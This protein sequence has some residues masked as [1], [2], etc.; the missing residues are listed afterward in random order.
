MLCCRIIS[1]SRHSFGRRST[2]LNPTA[3]THEFLMS[4]TVPT[5]PS[6]CQPLYPDLAE[7]HQPSP[8]PSMPCVQ[9]TN[10]ESSAFASSPNHDTLSESQHIATPPAPN[11]YLNQSRVSQEYHTL[12]EFNSGVHSFFT[13]GKDMSRFSQYAANYMNESVLR[14]RLLVPEHRYSSN[15]NRLT[16]LPPPSLTQLLSQLQS[17]PVPLTS[18]VCGMM[19]VTHSQLLLLQNTTTASV[20]FDESYKDA[21]QKLTRT[22]LVLEFILAQHHEPTPRNPCE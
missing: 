21:L 6:V 1:R 7:H 5:M 9:R 4:S 8:P 15:T 18:M 20:P 13:L 16:L 12:P 17:F 3:T 11:S 19:G 14:A 22:I 10:T 2:E